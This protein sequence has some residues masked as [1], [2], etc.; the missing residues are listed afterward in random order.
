MLLGEIIVTTGE[1]A[2]N[3]DK[4]RFLSKDIA[5]AL[6]TKFRKKMLAFYPS[7]INCH[8][9]ELI[10]EAIG[11][12]Y[13]RSSEDRFS[14]EKL[15]EE[16]KK[17]LLDRFD[18]KDE[19]NVIDVETHETSYTSA[20]FNMIYCY[21]Q[22]DYLIPDS[23]P[24]DVMASENFYN[25]AITTFSGRFLPMIKLICDIDQN[26]N[27]AF[28]G[29]IIKDTIKTTARQDFELE[30]FSKALVDDEVNEIKSADVD[31]FRPFNKYYRIL[32]SD[33][34]MILPTIHPIVKA[35]YEKSQLSSRAV[36]TIDAICCLECADKDPNFFTKMMKILQELKGSTLVVFVDIPNH[37]IVTKQRHSIE[38]DAYQKELTNNDD[39]SG[40][41]KIDEAFYR[42]MI[43]YNNLDIDDALDF[44]SKPQ[45][46]RNIMTKIDKNSEKENDENIK[47]LEELNRIVRD[48]MRTMNVVFAYSDI[49]AFE[50]NFLFEK[51]EDMAVAQSVGSI[52]LSDSSMTN[53]QLTT[54]GQSIGLNHYSL[55]N[56]SADKDLFEF[57]SNCVDTIVK[58]RTNQD[59]EKKYSYS[60]LYGYKYLVHNAFDYRFN[61]DAGG[62]E[63]FKEFKKRRKE[64]LDN[65]EG[66]TEEE[67]N[68]IRKKFG[69]ASVYGAI[70]DDAAIGSSD[71]NLGFFADRNYRRK[72][73]NSDKVD[74]VKLE[75]MVGL[76]EIKEQIHKFKSFVEMN[77]VKEDNNLKPIPV[78]KHMVFMGSPGTAK[79]SV[80]LQLARILND[81]GLIPTSDIKHVSRD[82][83]VGKYVGWTA[84]LVKEAIEDA[85]GG[86]LFV[87]EA[88][89][90]VAGEGGTNSYGME[91]IN[92]F[93]NYMDKADIRDSTIIIF[94]GYKDEM[95]EFVDSNPG[96]KS[97]IGFYFDF[98][99]YT[100]DELIEIAKIQAKNA[101][102]KLTDG[103]LE[104]LRE[105]IEKVRGAKDFGNG[106]FV[107]N[108]FEKSV[109][110]QSVR[111][112]DMGDDYIQNGKFKKDELI[113][114]LPEDFSTKGIDVSSSKKNVGFM[115][116]VQVEKHFK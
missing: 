44:P 98:P 65:L 4:G 93:V 84:R 67:I 49:M 64:A 40:M 68:A 101:E 58:E 12:H 62:N 103:Y 45:V 80:A 114:I 74:N 78:S 107:R 47:I 15:N 30:A 63:Y 43:E 79:T 83:L 22:D 36:Y 26:T 37:F 73:Y 14:F 21:K 81:A 97:R 24:H 86:I 70:D 10:V 16:I 39:A 51:F 66:K 61:T 42:K 85:K 23:D 8:S 72:D 105:V 19:Y 94:A 91:A 116:K 18:R 56:I 6:T 76:K 27:M 89:S 109:L 3:L 92:T 38:T 41:S 52:A 53:D 71:K 2:N 7:I 82:D 95:K 35:L 88:Y 13:L 54:F 17:F 55:N 60:S 69:A 9:V 31:G 106:R 75:D 32:V 28:V 57:I 50:Q 5:R 96:L 104:K 25:T 34:T 87:D 11:N 108:V 48:S 90:L 46:I 99:D 110:Q 115:S 33:R 102:Y 29:D 20:S 77:K 100:T 111:L 1:T 112:A 113:T 59:I